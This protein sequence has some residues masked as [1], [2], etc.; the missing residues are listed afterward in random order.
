MSSRYLTGLYD[1]DEIVIHYLSIQ[2]IHQCVR[3]CKAINLGLRESR[4]IIGLKPLIKYINRGCFYR[5][6]LKRA[7]KQGDVSV[8]E[9][10]RTNT[11]SC[12]KEKSPNIYNKRCHFDANNIFLKCVQYDAR[13]CI[14]FMLRSPL[15]DTRSRNDLSL[16]FAAKNGNCDLVE[17]L[18]IRGA[19]VNANNGEPLGI[20]SE[21]GFDTIVKLL[22][23]NG[24]NVHAA[25]N[26]ALRAAA[27]HGHSVIVKMLLEKGADANAGS[28]WNPPAFIN[29]IICG[30][31][32]TVKCLVEYGADIHI[33]GDYNGYGY[34]A[35]DYAIV[36]CARWNRVSILQWLLTLGITLTPR[37]CSIT[38]RGFTQTVS[39][40]RG[41]EALIECSSRGH[42]PMVQFLIQN[43]VSLNEC[44]TKCLEGSAY[45]RHLS[46]LEFLVSH[47]VS[48]TAE[49]LRLSSMYGQLP[50]VKCLVEHA[51]YQQRELNI[52]LR[53]TGQAYGS[54]GEGDRTRTRQYLISAGANPKVL[55]RDPIKEAALAT[56]Y[57]TY[58]PI[59][60]SYGAF[61]SNTT[62]PPPPY[63]LNDP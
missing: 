61:G 17:L 31:E 25:N 11:F 36:V 29:G 41:A 62:I 32:S 55:E 4:I 39:I 59:G 46:V 60:R 19:D 26:R 38:R 13:A 20:S 22:L 9:W 14:D 33:E 24:A 2:D 10:L 16:Q 18:I 12:S 42:L 23:E 34:C 53:N 7:I 52:A 45:N 21:N 48:P 28:T 57:A 50:I 8:L 49:A 47:G 40:D 54:S 15:V 27:L 3:I 44:G 35:E 1:T 5:M 43:G 58:F 51:T 56:Y 37:T 63:D 30:D 6:A